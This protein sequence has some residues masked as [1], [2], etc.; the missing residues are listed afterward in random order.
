MRILQ[1]AP[2]WE[3]VPPP[4]Y[5]GTEAVV[6]ILVEELVRRGHQ[7]TLCASGDS[8][9]DADLFSVYPPPPPTSGPATPT[10]GCTWPY[11]FGRRPPATTS[12]TTTP[13]SW[14]WP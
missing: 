14:P 11:R 3:A 7:V 2:L 9:T 6:S 10:T 12:F 1:L 8:S 4:A 5:G 13:V